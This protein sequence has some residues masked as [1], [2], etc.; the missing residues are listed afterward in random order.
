MQERV[1]TAVNGQGFWLG[2]TSGMDGIRLACAAVD[3]LATVNGCHLTLYAGHG[4]R[5]L[6]KRKNAGD[7]DENE[8]SITLLL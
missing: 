7:K 3:G 1:Q 2:F 6:Q 5:A 8:K 4:K